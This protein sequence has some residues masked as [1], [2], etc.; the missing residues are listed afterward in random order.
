[1]ANHNTSP[2]QSSS[3]TTNQVET[4]PERS[5][6]GRQL[7]R[8]TEAGLSRREATVRRLDLLWMGL[9]GGI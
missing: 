9:R 4:H 2:L 7:M 5:G 1:M 3:S 6:A 8:G